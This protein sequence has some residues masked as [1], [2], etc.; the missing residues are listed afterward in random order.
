MRTLRLVL[1]I[2][3]AA[4]IPACSGSDGQNGGD[5]KNGSD[6]KDAV[7][8]GAITGVVKD[9]QGAP[10]GSV[11][12]TTNPS[13]ITATTGGDGAFTLSG[14]AIGTYAVIATKDGYAPFTLAGVGVAAGGSTHV[15]LLLGIASNAPGAI[16]GIVTDAKSPPG[17][18]AG[19][20]V[21]VE[22]GTARAT[23]GA[24]GRFAIGGVAPGPVFL[25]A[26]APNDSYLGTE[27]RE[28]VFVAPG[29]TIG[30]VALVLSARPSD[31]ATYVGMDRALGCA[32]CHTAEAAALRSSAHFRS[33]TRIERDASGKATAGAFARMLN[34]TLTSPRI[35][36]V[37]LGGAV[38][39]SSVSPVITGAGT[40]FSM[41]TPGD[42]LGYT[43]VG[44]GWQ[45]LGV[46]QSIDSDAQVTLTANATLA[47]G[48]TT[49]AGAKYSARRLSRSYAHMLPEDASDIVAPAWPG[50]KA[51]NPSYDANDPCLYGNAP[52]GT[53]AAGGTTKY[54]DGQVN[55]YLCNLKDGVT[56][57]N[58]EYV[59]KFGGSPYTC[60]DGSFYNGSVAPAVPMVHIDV[61]Y[62]G[63][64]DK[65]GAGAPH[66]NMGVFK[67][68][69]QGR[70][71]DIKAADAWAYTAG[72]NLDSLTLPIQVLESGDKVNGGY[73]MNGYHPTEQKFP[74]ESWTQRT[75]TFSH[76]CAGCHN[77]G[78]QI[79]WSMQTVSLP[80][81]R[82]N[83]ATAMTFAAITSYKFKDENLTCEH[84]HGPG[85]D[86]L[87]FVPGKGVAIINP[88][89]L[90]A[91]AERQ[92]CGKCH[93]Y[94]DA[95]NAKPA[96]DYGFEYPWNSDH[97]GRLGGGDFVPGVYEL[98][99]FFDNWSERPS[100]DEGFW[101]PVETGGTLFGQAHRQQYT[102]LAQSKHDN[103]PYEK[104]TC[105][106]CHDAHTLY[107]GSSR[108]TSPTGAHYALT[109]ADYRNNVL[110]LGC[111]A[112]FGPFAS[113]SKDDVANIHVAGG[114]GATRDGA[115]LAPS[116][117][118]IVASQRA[119]SSS[120][121][122]HMFDKAHMPVA[123][124]PLDDASPLGRCTTCHM[125]KVAKSGGYVT[126]NDASN[127]PNKA[128]VEGDQASHVFTI[129]WPW[130][131]GA[132]SRG[133]PT[134][135]S[136]YYGQ[137]FSTSN[138]K[139][140]AFGFMP[141]S[142]S[143]CHA[144]ARQASRY[145]PDTTTVWPAFWPYSEH[146]DD[147]YWAACFTSS[148]AP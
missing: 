130:Q 85:S 112:G 8:T 71:A 37:P 144:S 48:T 19:V 89:Y 51:T 17:P 84:C 46:V 43:P 58:D 111:H 118:D 33:L 107:L 44:L 137:S 147:P 39:A 34:A 77:D 15:S 36:M 86:H 5:G 63:Q 88:R 24:D 3:V 16:S 121:G 72:K 119:I 9:A 47:P 148:T 62:G 92:L 140:D 21:S 90:S 133:G 103:N 108:V 50:V 55:V 40:Q 93:G 126:G 110:C 32:T 12:I 115:S 143:K 142:C 101:D 74:G 99:S 7:T 4:G 2:C 141:N 70:L 102:M 68:R 60:S 91:E 10:I 128:L 30:G 125:P 35:V 73:K 104:L 29:S 54:A 75:R 80:F 114:G 145:C 134:F 127:P 82:D 132:M 106:S 113:V 42:E 146:R 76:G 56:Y 26:A 45:K 6:G 105:T 53:C 31:S 57:L 27:T 69:F 65:D 13:S 81:A 139:Y 129:V 116:P 59:Q 22:G 135:Q 67:Q 79:E 94:D 124:N 1:T 78:L 122:A 20:V 38:S 120:V 136:G 66:K 117:E 25:A 52:S 98:G 41:L 11:A 100:D 18:L 87:S 109:A 14:V 96:Q 138:V 64:G 95:T 97:A 123:Y 23:T 83:A 28:A 61:I 49:L 131:S